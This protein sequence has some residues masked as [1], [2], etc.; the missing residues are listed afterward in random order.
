MLCHTQS[1]SW[2]GTAAN[3]AGNVLRTSLGCGTA[4]R[5]CASTSACPAQPL[6]QGSQAEQQGQQIQL[7][8]EP[9]EAAAATQGSVG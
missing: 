4:L 6:L 1:C 2:Q 9:R 7:P 3:P 5:G 8:Q